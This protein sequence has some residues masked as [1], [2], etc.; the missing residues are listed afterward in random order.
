VTQ[1]KSRNFLT[2]KVVVVA[3][4]TTEWGWRPFTVFDA[5][6]ACD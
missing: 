5:R 1:F 2:K 6:G 4:G 3:A